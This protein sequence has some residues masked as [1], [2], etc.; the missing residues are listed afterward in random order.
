MAAAYLGLGDRERALALAEESVAVSRRR[1]NRLWE[2]S[3]QL[4]RMRTLREVAGA[5]AIKDI[6]AAIAEAEVWLA[7]SGAKSYEPFS[8]SNVLSWL[9]LSATEPLGSASSAR[10]I[11]CSLRSARRSVRPRS[12]RNS[13]FELRQLPGGA[14]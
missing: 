6:E 1:G 13:A 4:I 2:F 8:T 7:M 3:A 5:G 9:G 11:G 12:R 14:S 10:R